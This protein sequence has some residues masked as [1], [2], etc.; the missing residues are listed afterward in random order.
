MCVSSSHVCVCARVCVFYIMTC[1]SPVRVCGLRERALVCARACVCVCV[2]VLMLLH[3]TY[4]SHKDLSTQSVRGCLPGPAV[5][6]F[7]A[8]ALRPLVWLSAA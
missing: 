2:C 6:G 8:V 1:V 7:A 5:P 4:V 3:R